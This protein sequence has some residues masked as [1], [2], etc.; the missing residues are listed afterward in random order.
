LVARIVGVARF[1]QANLLRKAAILLASTGEAR[2][3]QLLR[4]LLPR[5]RPPGQ[6]TSTRKTACS[7][8][9][10]GLEWSQCVSLPGESPAAEGTEDSGVNRRSCSFDTLSSS[11]RDIGQLIAHRPGRK[12]LVICLARPAGGLI[13]TPYFAAIGVEGHPCENVSLCT[14]SNACRPGGT[15]RALLLSTRF[16]RRA[17]DRHCDAPGTAE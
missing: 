6:R 11:A 8:D 5:R 1:L 16:R 17:W 12:R 7:A 9:L 15:S 3:P 2:F 4:R 14:D 10:G 13:R